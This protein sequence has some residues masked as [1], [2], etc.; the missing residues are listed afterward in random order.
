MLLLCY[1][2]FH[3]FLLWLQYK[4]RKRRRTSNNVR[5]IFFSTTGIALVVTPATLYLATALVGAK[6]AAVMPSSS[7]NLFIT[8]L[9][10]S[11]VPSPRIFTWAHACVRVVAQKEALPKIL[12]YTCSYANLLLKRTNATSTNLK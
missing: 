12:P 3:L 9:V 7:C 10:S 6:E 11:W 5:A 8:A 4:H 1:F 2:S